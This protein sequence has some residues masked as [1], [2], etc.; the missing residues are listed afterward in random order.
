MGDCEKAGL[1]LLIIAYGTHRSYLKWFPLSKTFFF[2]GGGVGV[3]HGKMQ[4][5]KSN[6][7]YYMPL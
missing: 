1:F 2:F 4:A 5:A 6:N 7:E 3:Y